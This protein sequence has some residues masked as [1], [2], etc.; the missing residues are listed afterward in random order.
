M[1]FVN[2]PRSHQ[3]WQGQFKRISRW[4][5][6]VFFAATVGFSIPITEML[7]GEAFGRGVL[8]AIGPVIGTKIISGLFAPASYA[9]LTKQQRETART[10][11]WV[12][13]IIQ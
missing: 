11:S 5:V 2:V 13:R 7:T 4:L 10:A 6:R 3:I 8:L 12:T 1:C 9:E